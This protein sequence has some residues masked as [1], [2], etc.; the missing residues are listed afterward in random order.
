MT[1]REKTVRLTDNIRTSVIAKKRR[2]IAT[3]YS[4]YT[5]LDTTHS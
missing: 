3:M 1:I 4:L 5:A 2:T